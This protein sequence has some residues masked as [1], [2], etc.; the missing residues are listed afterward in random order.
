MQVVFRVDSSTQIGSGHLMRC[1]TLAT[2]LREKGANCV[3]IC[4]SHPNNLTS[5]AVKKGFTV[6]ELPQGSDPRSA[7]DLGVPPEV[8]AQQTQDVLEQL[9][10]VDW[11]VVDHYG[12]DATW[13]KALR[14]WVK[15]IFVI[16]DLANRSHDCD[17]LLDQNY[18]HQQD[19]YAGLV[20]PYC[21]VLLGPQY[22]LL[23]SEFI[24]ARE[25]LEQEGC[26][27]FDPRKVFV[28][29]GGTDPKNYTTK[30]LE[31]LRSIGDFAPE[32]VISIANPHR[33]T[34]EAQ[35]RSFPQGELHIQTERMAEIMLRCSWYLGT[36][37]SV[38]WERMCLELRG[39]VIPTSQEQIPFLRLLDEIGYDIL[40]K[41]LCLEEI[42][43]AYQRNLD[44]L[45]KKCKSHMIVC[46][47]DILTGQ[48]VVRDIFLE[49]QDNMLS[50]GNI[51]LKP[52]ALADIDKIHQWKNNLSLLN[53][54]AAKPLP[55]T[56]EQTRLWL[57]KTLADQCQILF[58][59]YINENSENK[60][61]D[62]ELVGIVRLMFI[63]WVNRVCELGIYIGEEKYR[64]K[65]IGRRS[66]TLVLN[67]CFKNLNLHKVCLKT[68]KTNKQAINL[69]KS[70]GFKIEGIKRKE[71]W[72]EG[73]YEDIVIMGIF[74]DD[75][76]V[77]D[78][79]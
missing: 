24:A 41:N 74:F 75:L 73:R 34:V 77:V 61:H 33:S 62:S 35:M 58:G 57:D 44:Y 53:L 60:S 7:E 18:T 45:A 22:A 30:A 21:S 49:V 70:I 56:L 23:R 16:D 71:F 17:V 25:K 1:L 12:I 42:C 55:S 28:F 3:F 48:K 40:V 43:N 20:P 10:K 59:I 26:S 15:K 72:L 13:E 9:G 32:V 69:Y 29:F 68:L 38:T 52:P 65:G 11:L 79:S 76:D 8:D 50:D 14:P 31:I 4:R 6:Y 67:Y 78:K 47:S 5:L 37:G 39:I 51:T 63:D 19:R 66:T 46:L 64:G 2:A 27:S 54:V 36:G